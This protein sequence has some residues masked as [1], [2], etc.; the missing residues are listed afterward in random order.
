M[1]IRVD[2]IKEKTNC[3]L[4]AHNTFGLEVRADRFV[5]YDTVEDLQG[6]SRHMFPITL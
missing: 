3:S 1:K 5:E 6:P 4:R 2:M